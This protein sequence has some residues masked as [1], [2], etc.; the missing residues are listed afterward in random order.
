MDAHT[1]EINPVSIARHLEEL[2]PLKEAAK[3]QYVEVYNQQQRLMDEVFD[4]YDSL[5][6]KYQ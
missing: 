3:K 1:K 6:S 5:L 2:L 4:T